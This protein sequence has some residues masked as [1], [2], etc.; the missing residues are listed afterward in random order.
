MNRRRFC[1]DW[2]FVGIRGTGLQVEAR[3][4]QSNLGVHSTASSKLKPD[5]FGKRS[6]GVSDFGGENECAAVENGWERGLKG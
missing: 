2:L 5:P 1:S 6:N 4:L 3:S